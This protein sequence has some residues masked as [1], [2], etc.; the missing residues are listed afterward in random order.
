M[1]KPKRGSRNYSSGGRIRKSRL[2]TD[3]EDEKLKKTFHKVYGNQWTKI[4]KSLIIKAI[5]IVRLE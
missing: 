5:M 3:A 4:S 1:E 2:W